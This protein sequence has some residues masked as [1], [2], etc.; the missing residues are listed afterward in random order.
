MLDRIDGHFTCIDS[1]CGADAH[2]IVEED[3]LQWKIECAFCGTG[4]RVRGIR[5]HIQ[6]KT[7]EFRFADGR[8]EGLTVAEAAAEPRGLEYVQWAAAN[9]KRPAVRDA[10][11]THI[12]AQPVAS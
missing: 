6:Q 3:G 12:D 2:D 1:R 5:G 7:Q 11:K 4:Q 9:H 8:F 10:C